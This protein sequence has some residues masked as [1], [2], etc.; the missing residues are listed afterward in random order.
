MVRRLTGSGAGVDVVVGKAGAGKTYALDAARAAWQRA[1]FSVQGV[2]LS[3]QAAAELEAGSGI[4]SCTL[5]R[6]GLALRRGELF[7]SSRDV[8]VLDE[9]GMVGSRALQELLFWADLGH[10]KVGLVGDQRQLPEIEA[11]GMLRVLAQRLGAVTLQANRRQREGWERV[12]LDELRHGEPA[13]ALAA[14]ADHGRV[15]LCDSARTAR[16]TMVQAWAEARRPGETLR[17]YALTRQDTDDLNLLAREEL[18]ARGQLGPDAFEAAGRLFA[19]GDEVL[20]RRND[21]RLGVLNGTRGTVAEANLFGLV[22]DTDLGTKQL[23]PAAAEEVHLA[24]SYAST[25]HKSQGETVDRAFVLGGDALYRE[26]G[27]VAMSRARQATDLY[28]V[29]AAF[30][31]GVAPSALDVPELGRRGL[32]KAL[33]TSR[34]KRLALESLS[35]GRWG[36]AGVPEPGAEAA[37]IAADVAHRLL[38][39]VAAVERPAEVAALLGEPPDLAGKR[40]RWGRAS[41]LAE[42]FCRRFAIADRSAALGREPSDAVMGVAQEELGAQLSGLGMDVA[43]GAALG[44]ESGR[45]ARGRGIGR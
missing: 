1:G 22:V 45:P 4:A 30:D 43:D 27:Y 29:T 42:S 38:G 44:L 3:A 14:Y 20:F 34:A 41:G 18:R 36:P 37:R 25:V 11:G 5:A 32:L 23:D 19:V 33:S 40:S 31:E 28:V 17:M 15:H 16:V 6:I 8:V 10:A 26:A 13:A 2:A 9:A 35:G 24:H 7:L 12:A 39:E 21:R